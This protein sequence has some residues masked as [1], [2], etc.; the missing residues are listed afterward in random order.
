MEQGGDAVGGARA[1]L[2]CGIRWLE[3]LLPDNATAGCPAVILALA[4]CAASTGKAICLL[5]DYNLWREAMV[6]SRSV[7]EMMATAALF[8]YEPG[9]HLE[10]VAHGKAVPGAIVKGFK[11][12]PGGT[13]SRPA[14]HWF[15]GGKGRRPGF[16]GIL[17]RL[18]QYDQRVLT[19]I[20]PAYRLGCSYAH[21]DVV[22]LGD[23]SELDSL[24][25]TLA[26]G[27]L[28]YLAFMAD[29]IW[30]EDRYETELMA[31]QAQL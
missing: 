22:A 23:P 29:G 6:L 27:C 21:V 2:E 18:F 20:D 28:F 25:C 19:F 9:L 12:T 10:F 5:V 13:R 11:V 16:A 3:R 31:A 8:Q 1:R 24:A 7:L 17:E 26:A 15:R 14:G 30:R 4:K